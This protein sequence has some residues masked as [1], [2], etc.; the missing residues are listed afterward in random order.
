MQLSADLCLPADAARATL[1]GRVWRPGSPGGPSV[2]TIRGDG[3][4]DI[5]RLAPTV[6]ELL[7]LADPAGAARGFPG[8]RI[9]DVGTVIAGSVEGR[10]DPTRPHLLAPCDLQ[11][12][13][14]CGVT[15]AA[16]LLERVIE[17]QARG[18]P[19]QAETV[20][21][22]VAEAIGGDLA[23]LRP[24]SPEA[25][26]L[27]A[28]LVERGAW[29]QYIEVGIG[30]DAEVFTKSQPMAAVG[31]GA[32]IGIHPASA[33]NNPEP[34][35]VLAI[36]ATGRIV[37]ATL[38]NDV[39]LR[40]VEGRSALLLGKAK[41]NTGSC[42]I[43]PFIRLFD[44]G[45]SLDDVRAAELALTVEG[46]DGFRLRGASSMRRISRDVAELAAQAIGPTHQYP[47]GLML[48]TGTMFAPVDDRDAPGRGFTH[49]VGDVVTIASPL[50]GALVNRVD[51]S[52][53]LPP[54]E[55]GVTALMRNLAARGLL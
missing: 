44:E 18:D 39:N 50:L 45:F 46:E 54:W 3:V 55:F 4:H 24:G 6:S 28:V 26:R 31:L 35:I 52:D 12:L 37:G 8:E 21:Q 14:A 30:P 32:G 33:W 27:K 51:T 13:K 17:E 41:D 7:N 29:S 20:R 38:G 9:G 36:A 11:A 2:V 22:S 48:F 5:S 15:F 49:H 42:A 23:R 19:A 43:G 34:E 53:R 25:A 1:I 16:S 40:D 10:R 47:D